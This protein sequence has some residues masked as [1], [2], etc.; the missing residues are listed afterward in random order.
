MSTAFEIATAIAE[1]LTDSADDFDL[2]FTAVEEW[3]PCRELSDLTTDPIIT[4]VPVSA[5]LETLSRAAVKRMVRIDVAI[6]AK[7]ADTEPDTISP[8]AAFAEAVAQFLHFLKLDGVDA[9]WARG[10]HSPIFSRETA[11]EF[12]AFTSIVSA[13]YMTTE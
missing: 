5:E 13:W 3:L 11:D 8:L 9:I 4:V 6:Q 10:A 7:I 2:D 12:S 1:A